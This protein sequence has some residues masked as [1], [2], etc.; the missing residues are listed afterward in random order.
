VVLDEGYCLA[1][2]EAHYRCIL[3]HHREIGGQWLFV[4]HEQLMGGDGVSRMEA[5]LKLQLDKALVK[6]ELSRTE[7][8]G[9]L[10]GALPKSSNR[11]NELEKG[12]GVKTDFSYSS[13]IYDGAILAL[14]EPCRDQEES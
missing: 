14:A 8:D 11:L 12:T 6:Q 13:Q 4:S 2:W 1:V 9:P 10:T 7:A 5:F 3:E